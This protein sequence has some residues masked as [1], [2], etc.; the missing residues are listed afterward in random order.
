MHGKL[1]GKQN[2]YYEEPVDEADYVMII[3]ANP[4]QSHGVHKARKVVNELSRDA[5]RTLVV[6]DPRETETAKKANHF[7]QIIPGRDAFLLSAMIG[8]IVQ[9]GLEDKDF[10][11]NHTTGFEEINPHFMAIPV[12]EY[13]QKSGLDIDEVKQIARDLA[14]ADSVCIRSDLG[15]EMSYNS[16]LNSYLKRLLFLVT[17]NF[18]RKNTNHLVSFFFPLIGHS[19][20]P[21]DGGLVTQVTGTKEIC[22]LFPPN[23]LPLE[24]DSDHPKRT[25]AIIVESANPLSSYADIPAQRKAYKKL[26]LMVVI[27]VVNDR[28][29]KSCTLYSPRFQSI[30]EIRSHIFQR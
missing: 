25:R 5:K 29:G 7:L 13:I 9:E 20:E 16:T 3:G 14:A 24:I 11:Q 17:G 10:I 30:R 19:K 23:V 22:K 6:V 12:E 8:L 18:G 15:L 27:D 1:F 28:N 4:L 2:T 26:D 21:E